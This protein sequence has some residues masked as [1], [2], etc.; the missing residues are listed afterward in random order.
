MSPGFWHVL[1]FIVIPL[2]IASS[3][4]YINLT[5]FFSGRMVYIFMQL[6]QNNHI[7]IHIYINMHYLASTCTYQMSSRWLL[8]RCFPGVV[9]LMMKMVSLMVICTILVT[10][11]Q[12]R[13]LCS[14]CKCLPAVFQVNISMLFATSSRRFDLTGR[15]RRFLDV[16][17]RLETWIEL[18]CT[19]AKTKHPSCRIASLNWT[20]FV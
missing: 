11:R 16:C 6:S 3:M 2:I 20:P 14:C 7:N 17:F 13:S 8:T 9:L 5:W 18:S 4:C 15:N 1:K 19:R 12:S 10:S